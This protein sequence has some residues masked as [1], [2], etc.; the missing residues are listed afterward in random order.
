ML[1]CGL[2]GKWPIARS[3]SVQMWKFDDQWTKQ[4]RSILKFSRD[5]LCVPMH[6]S[7]LLTKLIT[8]DTLFI[9]YLWIPFYGWYQSIN[10]LFSTQENNFTVLH[11]ILAIPLRCHKQVEKYHGKF[12]PHKISD[13]IYSSWKLGNE[14]IWKYAPRHIHFN[15]KMII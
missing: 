8:F 5:C 3:K 9:Y 13:T 11:L 7:S 2:C 1:V 14:V 12:F 6:S 15:V 10:L 4:P